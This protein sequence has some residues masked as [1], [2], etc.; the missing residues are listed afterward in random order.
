MNALP[1]YNIGYADKFDT[2]FYISNGKMP[3]RN[4]AYDWTKTVPGNSSET[5][6]RPTTKQRSFLKVISPA[7]GFVYNANHSPFKSSG[8]EDN[9]DPKDFAKGYGL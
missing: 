4:P 7:S 9:P 1:G 6:W 3:K 8:I 5:L 2:I